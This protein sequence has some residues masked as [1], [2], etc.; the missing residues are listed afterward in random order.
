MVW[1][2]HTFL[3]VIPYS[4]EESQQNMKALCVNPIS[5][6]QNRTQGFTNAVLMRYCY[7]SMLG[8]FAHNRNDREI[9]LTSLLASAPV[10]KRRVSLQSGLIRVRVDMCCIIVVIDGTF[11]FHPSLC[12]CVLIPCCLFLFPLVFFIPFFSPLFCKNNRNPK[13]QCIGTEMEAAWCP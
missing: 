3:G 6:T 8:V 7:I 11:C 5:W 4:L 2:T 9:I 12:I 10:S 1:A 13:S